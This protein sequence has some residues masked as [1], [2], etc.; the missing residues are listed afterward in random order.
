MGELFAISDWTNRSPA[1]MLVVA[2]LPRTVDA[3]EYAS[4]CS[5]DTCDTFTISRSEEVI[6]APWGIGIRVART[7]TFLPALSYIDA[8]IAPETT[9]TST[10]AIMDT[11]FLRRCVDNGIDLAISPPSPCI[12][13][14]E[15]ET[16][17]ACRVLGVALAL[18]RS[19][20][21]G[22]TLSGSKLLR[23]HGGDVSVV[24]IR[25]TESA[26]CTLQRQ[27]SREIL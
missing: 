26:I 19:V 27:K 9:T 14:F 17:G 1:G 13:A 6:W 25:S 5:P 15:G 11:G 2:R 18:L 21:L 16:G 24:E 10:A 22:G 4:R 3:C 7:S 20:V 12:R 8:K 23:L